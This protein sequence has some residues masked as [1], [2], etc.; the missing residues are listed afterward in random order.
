MKPLIFFSSLIALITG[1]IFIN[2]S[3]AQN[4][5]LNRSLVHVPEDYL[6]IQEAIN[7]VSDAD[8]V[9]VH[10]GPIPKTLISMEKRL[11][12]HPCTLPQAMKTI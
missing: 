6:S 5:P 12:W 7:A 2:A 3:F 4:T 8:T 1:A 10:P 9:L 11:C